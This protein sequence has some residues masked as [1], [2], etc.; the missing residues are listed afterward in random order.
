MTSTAVLEVGAPGFDSLRRRLEHLSQVSSRKTL[1]L[2]AHLCL[3]LFAIDHEGNENS[4]SPSLFICGKASQPFPPI[5]K[6]FNV[7]IQGLI[8]TT[9][10]SARWCR[11]PWSGIQTDCTYTLS[12]SYYRCLAALRRVVGALPPQRS[13]QVLATRLWPG[14]R[15][16]TAFPGASQTCPF[17]VGRTCFQLSTT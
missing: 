17:A 8:L 10:R 13:P 6:F 11:Q 14:K 16:E 5:Y 12:K 1:P 9:R 7:E 2:F 4:F 3:N 15:R